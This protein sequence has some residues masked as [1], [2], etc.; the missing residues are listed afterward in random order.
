MIYYKKQT[1]TKRKK[2]GN[3]MLKVRNKIYLENAS[4]ELNKL[5]AKADEEDARACYFSSSLLELKAGNEIV[6]FSWDDV[7]MILDVMPE[8]DVEEV[9]GMDDT[10]YITPPFMSTHQKKAR[11]RNYN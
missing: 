6:V 5:M 2:E 11:A 4:E 10:Y 7:A 1:K 3:K 9:E 8:A